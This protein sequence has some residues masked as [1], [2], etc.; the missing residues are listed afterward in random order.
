[1]SVPTSASDFF[2]AGGTLHADTPSYVERPTDDELFHLTLSGEFCYMLTPRQMG[3]SSLMIRTAQRLQERGVSTAIVDLTLIGTDA[4]VERWYLN[5]LTQLARR[6]KLSLNPV[7]WWHER[8]S[9][10]FVQRFTDFLR[11]VILAEVEGRVVV[12]IDEIDTTLNLDFRDDFFAA[13]RATYNA[14][15]DDPEFDRLTFVLLGVAS[16]PDLIK[17]RARTPFNIGQGIPLQE[18]TQADAAVLRDGLEAVLPG[19][20]ETIFARIYHWTNGHPYLTQKLC[21]AVAEAGDAHWTDERVDELVE[22]LFL[23][24]EARKETNLQFVQ[25][26]ILT[27]PQRRELLTLYRKVLQ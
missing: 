17:D 8:A 16:P 21:L 3:K 4:T 11:H 14:R 19:Q 9:L 10:G 27:H 1:M 20:G 24:E 26:K 15:A 2:V 23:S 5:L 7:A 25:D 13:I 18:F 12:F 22:S 6:L